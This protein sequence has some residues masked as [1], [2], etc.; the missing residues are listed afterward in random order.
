MKNFKSQTTNYKQTQNPNNQKTKQYDLEPRTQKFAADCRRLLQQLPKSLSNLED[1]KQLLRSSGSTGA[2]YIEANEALS[3]K[4]FT[5]RIKIS[6]KEAKESRY[7][8]QL[9]QT[10]TSQLTSE[11]DRLIDEATQ[12]IKIFTAILENSK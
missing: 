10:A 11:R 9:I 12:L 5:F 1:G 7:W 8:L 6:R 4:D 2:N 3:R